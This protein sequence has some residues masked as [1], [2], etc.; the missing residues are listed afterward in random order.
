M[1][2][3]IPL[4]QLAQQ[5]D[6]HHTAA[7]RQLQKAE[8]HYKSAGLYL[9]EARRRIQS[10]E[11]KDFKTFS[12]FCVGGCR[13]GK[14][15]AYEMIAIAEERTSLEEIREKNAKANTV[16][17]ERQRPSRDGHEANSLTP[18]GNPEK[19]PESPKQM[20]RPRKEVTP[21][22]ALIKEITKLLK[23]MEIE[24]LRNIHQITKD[25]AHG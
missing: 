6:G 11:T 24:T 12:A 19:T 1:S 5:I 17:R 14:S 2:N 23:G 7:E 20:G 10:G 15:R 8:D 4:P 25:M 22:A 21:E 16:Y 13:V 18:Q 9:I 3:L